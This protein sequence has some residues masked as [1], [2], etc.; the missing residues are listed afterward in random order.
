MQL[1]H[2]FL[3]SD[4]TDQNEPKHHY[5]VQ[6][7]GLGAFVLFLAKSVHRFISGPNRCIECN[8]S[9]VSGTVTKATNM[10]QYITIGLGAFV[11]FLAE[12]VHRFISGPNRCIECNTSMGSGIVTKPTKT[13][14]NI[15][16]VSKKVDWVRSFQFWPETVHRFVSGPNRCT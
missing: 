12:S 16:I 5:W 1:W 14:Q 9:M 13:N 15:N 4:E 7:T 11:S 3:Y 2:G 10:N 6:K 8:P